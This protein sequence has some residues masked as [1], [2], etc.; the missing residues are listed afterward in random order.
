MVVEV[1]VVSMEVRIGVVEEEVLGEI[2]VVVE[3]IEGIE[4][5]REDIVVVD[6]VD[7]GDVVILPHNIH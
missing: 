5:E 4:V 6:V 1:G 3:V 7:S 2:I